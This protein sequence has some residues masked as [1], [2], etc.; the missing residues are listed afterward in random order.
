[1]ETPV[2]SQRTV[3]LEVRRIIAETLNAPVDSVA[4]TDTLDE[5]RLGVDSLSL[6][7]LNVV[8]EERFDITIPDFV[9]TEIRAP[10]SVADVVQMVVQGIAAR[11]GGAS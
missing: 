3:T 2:P 6:I 4:L 11:E 1:M 10:R 7:K 9:T 8:L 5:P